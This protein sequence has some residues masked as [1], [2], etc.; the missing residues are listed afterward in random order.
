M[1]EYQEL[2]KNFERIRDYMRQFFVYGFKVRNEFTEKSLRTYDNERRRI[3]S[4]LGEYIKS[5]YSEKGKQIAITIDSKEIS[6]NPL[7]A[8]WKAKSFTDNDILF[9]FYLLEELGDGRKLSVKEFCD[10]ISARYGIVFDA[11]TAR[12]KFKEYEK[13]QILISSRIGKILYYQL[14]DKL[15][16]EETE[17]YQRLMEAVK[18]FQEIAPFGFIGSTLLDR[19]NLEN[20]SFRFKHH[21]LV[22]T[23]ED[24]V[25]YQILHAGRC[26]KRIQFLNKSARTGNT[27]VQN[28]IPL[29]IFVSTRTGRRY[30]CIFNNIKRRFVNIRL[31][32]ICDIKE[33]E[34]YSDYESC[35]EKLNKNEK[36]CWGV[37]FGS[38]NVR[39]E[40]VYIKLYIK[41]P[42]E[43]FVLNR[44]YREGRGG[45][46]QQI[47]DNIYLYS[48]AFFDSNE[49]L[50][51][52]KSFIGRIIDIQGTNSFVI[53]KLQYDLERMYRMYFED[54][55][56]DKKE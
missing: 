26:H 18:L 21:Y 50:P 19:E 34:E 47:Q 49:M 42:E 39:I 20:D 11:Q 56:S 9:H 8:V 27:S 48:G 4:Y 36:K 3:E 55:L 6:Q 16:F 45:E 40:E 14:A 5:E 35:L 30:L 25:L 29:K 7:Y 51:W 41:M 15:C 33:L 46:V 54:G 28:G 2:I 52:V 37:S 24:N 22:H 12:L 13:E 38:K 31:D 44:L 23:L 53:N 10:E 1:S 32:A 43:Q 17:A